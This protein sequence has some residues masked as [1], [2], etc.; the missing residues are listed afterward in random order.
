MSMWVSIHSLASF[1]WSAVLFDFKLSQFKNV[2]YLDQFC[3]NRV[4]VLT[5]HQARS[6]RVTFR[7]T[8]ESPQD[9][10][11]LKESKQEGRA[12][13]EFCWQK[14][15]QYIVSEAFVKWRCHFRLP[16]HQ[17]ATIQPFLFFVRFPE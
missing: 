15:F 12:K 16:F 7:N 10:P 14:G 6:F 9:A 2:V 11:K 3:S 13:L 1:V 8:S 4:R 17:V 5:F